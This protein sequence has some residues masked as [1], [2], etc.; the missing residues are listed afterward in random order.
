[1]N[2]YVLTPLQI[3]MIMHYQGIAEPYACRQPEHANS[4]AVS[5]QRTELVA[6]DL[7][8]CE[9]E[10]PSGYRITERGAAYVEMLCNTPLPIC[11]WVAP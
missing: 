7:L 10:S 3:M 8:Q 6:L 5:G 2:S 9:I 1:M 11:K 4:R